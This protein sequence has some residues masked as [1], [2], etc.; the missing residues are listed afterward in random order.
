MFNL[1]SMRVLI[2]SSEG[3]ITVIRIFSDIDTCW[4]YYIL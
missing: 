3:V 2:H 1:T 4:C